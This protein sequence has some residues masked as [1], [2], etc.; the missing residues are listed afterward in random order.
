MPKLIKKLQMNQKVE[1]T[2]KEMKKN[3]KNHFSHFF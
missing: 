1:E 2:I 3:Q